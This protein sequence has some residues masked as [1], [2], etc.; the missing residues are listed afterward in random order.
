MLIDVL[1]FPEK[2]VSRRIKHINLMYV[3]GKSCDPRLAMEL[4]PY[5]IPLYNI[6]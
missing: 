6:Y 2:N 4:F 1:F 3:I 5:N